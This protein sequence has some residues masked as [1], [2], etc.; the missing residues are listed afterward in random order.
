MIAIRSIAFFHGPAWT[1]AGGALT[2]AGAGAGFP[3]ASGTRP[4]SCR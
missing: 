1:G 3:A 2:G 4:G